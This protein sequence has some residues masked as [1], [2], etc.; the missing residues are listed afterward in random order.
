MKRWKVGL[1][2]YGNKR[3]SHP[4][5]SVLLV[6]STIRRALAEDPRFELRDYTPPLRDDREVD[7]EAASHI[8]E[9]IEA[10]LDALVVQASCPGLECLQAAAA[11]CP[12]AVRIVHRDSSHAQGHRDIL[13]A[14]QER[15][16][17]HY[18]L[19][20]DGPLLQ[21]ELAE[22]DLAD[23]VTVASRWAQKTFADHGYNR[24][25]HVGPQG[26]ELK[27]WQAP[28]RRWR[29]GSHVFLTGGQLGLRKGVLDA[30][31]AWRIAGAPGELL[32]AGLPDAAES[33]PAIQA[34]IDATPRC[35]AVGHVQ[36]GT[37]LAALYRSAACLVFPSHEEGAA[38]IQ[39]EAMASGL[40][41]IGTPNG[42]CDILVDGRSDRPAPTGFEV[43]AGRPDLIAEAILAYARDEDMRLRHA[44]AAAAA[45]AQCDVSAYAR[46]YASAVAAMLS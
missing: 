28:A 32:V 26:I 9:K 10:D 8:H 45:A 43:P 30:L 42:G 7:Y 11:R 12:G 35:R 18:P 20:Y 16:G 15:Y 25:V 37:P 40:P 24:C 14:Q 4:L 38:M 1:A 44:R 27:R 22:Y 39:F 46:R 21:R 34:A 23:F 2:T 19:H 36:F 6:H 5:N 41:L 31:E 3:K 17:I 13:R 29:A 33:A